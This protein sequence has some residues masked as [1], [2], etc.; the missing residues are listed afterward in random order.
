MVW[1]FVAAD[2]LSENRL[3]LGGSDARHVGGALRIRPGE[4]LTAVTPDGMAHLCTVT[5]ATS[6]NV[7]AEVV[8]SRPAPA[9]PR[10]HVR[11]A[12]AFLKGDQLERIL[13]AGAEAGASSF[14][15]LFSERVVARPEPARLE[16]KAARWAGIVRAG[17]ELAHRGRLPLVLEA[18]GL[19][20]A[21]ET[22]H[23][24]GL[25]PFLL[26]EGAGLRSLSSVP[27]APVRGVCLVVGPEGGWSE[28]EVDLAQRAGAEAVTL[29][30]R[31]M[32]P[33]PAALLALGVI[34]H[35]AGELQSKED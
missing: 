21:L 22:A 24:D 34:L 19:G 26:F 8:E 18:A 20:E 5:G 30:P 35:R 15:P 4:E 1:I 17:A 29:G 33:L 23:A 7:D 16:S 12:V 27:L 32:R 3:H 31:I 2:A 9:E 6:G 13:E 14:Q 10:L 11:L 28:A 25:Q